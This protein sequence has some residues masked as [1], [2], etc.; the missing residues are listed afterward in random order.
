MSFK[1]LLKGNRGDRGSERSTSGSRAPSSVR[2]SSGRSTSVLYLGESRETR[3]ISGAFSYDHPHLAVDISGDL[4][5]AG[6]RLGEPG[7]YDALAVGWSL[8]ESDAKAFITQ[9]RDK[10]LPIAI[11][12]V[13]EHS[14]DAL[15]DAGAD[16]CVQKGGSLLTKLPSA[17]EEAVKNRTASAEAT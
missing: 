15:R 12:A 5:E 2:V 4:S 11:V 7:R 16:Q 10:A 13:G 14:L 6:A 17:I 8:P 1:Q 9:L 3:L